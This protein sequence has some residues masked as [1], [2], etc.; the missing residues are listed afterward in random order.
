MYRTT[1]VYCFA[2]LGDLVS[3]CALVTG[4]AEEAECKEVT[5]AEEA[6]TGSRGLE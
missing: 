1:S 5:G 3:M 4:A 2:T 6:E